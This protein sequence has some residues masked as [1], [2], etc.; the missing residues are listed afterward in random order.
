VGQG[1]RKGRIAGR[2]GSHERRPLPPDS[3]GREAGY[4]A[5]LATAG[6]PLVVQLSSGEAIQGVIASFDRHQIEISRP[7]GEQRI[8]RRSEIR[9]LYEEPA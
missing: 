6:T 7:D 3:T 2:R 1:K 8:L 5:Q 4:F 9:Y